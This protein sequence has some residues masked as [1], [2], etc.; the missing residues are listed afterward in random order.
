MPSSC[1]ASER[2]VTDSISNRLAALT[3]AAPGKESNVFRIAA[4]VAAAVAG[5]GC[6][7]APGMRM[8]EGAL[9]ERGRGQGDPSRYRV[10]L[11][12]SSVLTAQA[13]ARAEAE[14]ARRRDRPNVLPPD[15]DYRIA[16]HDVLSVIVWEHPEL[17]IP[18]GEFRSA[19][20]SG[21][22]VSADGDIFFPHVGL[23][24]V[25][26]LTPEEIRLTLTQRLARVVKQPQL[27]VLVAAYRGKRAQ[28]SGE[29]VAPVAV[30]IT[31]VPLRVQDAI[32][33]A[34]GF[35]PDADPARVT[36]SRGGQAHQLDL[37]ALYEGGDLSQNWVLQDGDVVHVPDRS[38][39]KIFVL[40]EVK[41]PAVRL[42]PKGRL[43]L[44]DAIADLSELDLVYANPSQIFVFRGQY[45]APEIY[46]L[47]A[48]SPDALLLATEFRLRPRDVVFVS[49]TNLGRFSRVVSH[50]IPTVQALWQTYDV[51]RLR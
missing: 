45:D 37:L 4:L 43:T 18:A 33:L 15:A 20:T 38:Q 21:F 3:L 19:E 11:I 42:M 27:Q 32:A 13:K 22:P 48:S 10:V 8:N 5:S 39:N 1:W 46:R 16:P 26:G 36:L 23:L 31:D 47:D 51:A 49:T 44:A 29:V 24:R 35:T 34:R 2:R 50:I 12:T 9:E 25:A 7:L 30:P 28:V 14:T 41:K 17:T 40:G 6:F